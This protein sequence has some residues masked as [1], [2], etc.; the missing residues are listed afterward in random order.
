MQHITLTTLKTWQ[1]EKRVF[2]LID[3]RE[4]EEHEAFNIGGQLI[5]LG[6]IHRNIAVF[7]QSIPVVVYCKRGI[8]SQVAIQRLQ[9][10]L[11]TVAFYNL[12]GGILPLL[13]RKN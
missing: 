12:Q 13:G 3:V 8:R 9:L 7:D 10:K 4:E 11:K 2:K 6:T 5:P 1:A